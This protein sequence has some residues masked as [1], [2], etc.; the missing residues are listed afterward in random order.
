MLIRMTIENWASFRDEVEFS[1][2]ASRERQHGDRLPVL[3]S[4]SMRVLPVAAIYG[5]NASCKDSSTT[6][7][8]V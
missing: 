7:E 5:G 2:V 6:P 8:R 1:M 4:P 3:S